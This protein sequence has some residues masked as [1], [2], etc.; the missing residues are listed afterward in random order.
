M[1]A[2]WQ[3]WN[4]RNWPRCFV[5]WRP[6]LSTI[7]LAGLT[8]FAANLVADWA[9]GRRSVC[10][11]HVRCF[12]PVVS[13]FST[14]ALLRSMPTRSIGYLQI[15]L[16]AV[17]NVRSFLSL[18]VLQFLNSAVRRS[19]SKPMYSARQQSRKSPFCECCERRTIGWWQ[20]ILCGCD[21]KYTWQFLPENADFVEYIVPKLASWPRCP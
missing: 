7:S 12:D 8:P 6:T 17:G 19:V 3:S 16:I 9:K 13:S 11:S 10:V 1:V 5:L 20:R 2:T 15:S 21:E 14:N 18:I 4:K